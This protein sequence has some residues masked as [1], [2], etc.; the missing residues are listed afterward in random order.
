MGKRRYRAVERGYGKFQ[1]RSRNLLGGN[2]GNLPCPR[3]PVLFR[4]RHPRPNHSVSIHYLP[5][6]FV[7]LRQRRSYLKSGS[8]LP[9]YVCLLLAVLLFIGLTRGAAQHP[10]TLHR[11]THEWGVRNLSFWSSTDGWNPLRRRSR[12]LV[13][14]IVNMRAEK[15]TGEYNL[16][17]REAFDSRDMT[18]VTSHGQ[19]SAVP[20]AELNINDYQQPPGAFKLPVTLMATFSHNCHSYPHEIPS[21][22]VGRA[23]YAPSCRILHT[24][25]MLSHRQGRSAYLHQIKVLGE[26][27]GSGGAKRALVFKDPEKDRENVVLGDVASVSPSPSALFP[28]ESQQQSAG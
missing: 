14:V 12:G 21:T 3:L 23:T 15:T 22:H 24:I 19:P 17:I 20:R 7:S 25:L 6:R 1:Q 8:G 10:P 5:A 26:R 27:R 2:E 11:S 28:S 18:L 16:L 9:N 4:Q 13:E